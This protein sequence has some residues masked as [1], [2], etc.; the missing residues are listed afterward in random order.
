MKKQLKVGKVRKDKNNMAHYLI[1]DLNSLKSVI[2]PLFDKYSL[3]TIKQQSYKVFKE[4]IN[5]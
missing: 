3:K 4:S 2:I 5:I 1:R